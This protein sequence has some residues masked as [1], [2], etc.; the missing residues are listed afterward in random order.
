[1]LTMPKCLQARLCLALG[2]FAICDFGIHILR[3]THWRFKAISR[4]PPT[5][6]MGGHRRTW[7][8]L[9]LLSIRYPA[10]DA[11]TF[12]DIGCSCLTFGTVV[13]AIKVYDK[14]Y[15]RFALVAFVAASV[16]GRNHV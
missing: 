13:D 12:L 16:G 6:L 1:M 11:K 10:L 3:D 7:L 4:R 8:L 5:C 14:P 2:H 9:W 15:Q